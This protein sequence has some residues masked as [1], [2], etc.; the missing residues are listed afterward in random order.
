LCA[1]NRVTIID[2][3]GWHTCHPNFLCLPNLCGYFGNVIAA[4]QGRFF[5][6]DDR[7]FLIIHLGS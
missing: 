1:H 4:I 2:H 3:I 7:W 6:G 5:G